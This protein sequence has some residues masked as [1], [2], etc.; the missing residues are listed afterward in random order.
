MSDD[1]RHIVCPHCNSVNRIPREKNARAAK[2]GHCHQPIFAGRPVSVS[3]ASFATHVQRNDIPV[4]VDFWAQW[5]GPCKVMAPVYE[6]IASE[7]EPELRFL[8]VDTEAEPELAA[9]HNIRNIP[10][11]VLFHKGAEIARQAGVMDAE[12]LRSWLR[13][14]AASAISAMQRAS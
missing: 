6:R 11:L 2:C 5:C 1:V 13:R 9:R 10:T 12:S 7:L 14:N 3:A 4:V 8:K